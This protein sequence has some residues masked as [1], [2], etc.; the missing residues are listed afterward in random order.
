MHTIF[1][2]VIRSRG[3]HSSVVSIP[4][5]KRHPKSNLQQ[6]SDEVVISTWIGALEARSYFKTLSV[7]LARTP[8]PQLVHVVAKPSG[9]HPDLNEPSSQGTVVP[10]AVL[11]PGGV[12]ASARMSVCICRWDHCKCQD[13]CQHAYLYVGSLQ[14][15]S[16]FLLSVMLV[17]ASLAGRVTHS[18]R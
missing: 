11:Y 6:S 7:L 17:T 15:A 5:H 8:V 3:Q 18:I 9:A 1:R 4:W 2:A 16:H 12:T 10:L 13:V 14:G